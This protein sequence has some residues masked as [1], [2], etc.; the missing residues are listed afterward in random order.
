M[1]CT[2]ACTMAS[3]MPVPAMPSRSTPSRLKGS[4]RWLICS[5]SSPRPVSSTR[6]S[7]QPASGVA[8][9][10]TLPPGRLYLIALLSRLS[11]TW[12]SRTGSA[13]TQPSSGP[14]CRP[15]PWS[16]ASSSTSGRLVS[17][18]GASATG[19]KDSGNSPD[20][21]LDR[22]STSSISAS[23]CSPEAW[24]CATRR[25]QVAGSAPSAISSCEKPSTA[26]SGVRS[27]WLMRARK[28]D[29]AWLSRCASWRSSRTAAA[30][31][32]SV[33]SQL[34][35][36][37]RTV[38]P[39]SSRTGVDREA[40]QR[41]LPSGSTTRNSV[42]VG[43]SPRSADCRLRL[44]R[45]RSAG[46]SQASIWSAVTGPATGA[47]PRSRNICSSHQPIDA[48]ASDSQVPMPA[49]RAA[50]AARSLACRSWSS[51]LWRSVTSSITPCKWRWPATPLTVDRLA[52]R[53]TRPSGRRMRRSRSSKP[54]RRC[55]SV[56]ML[57]ATLARSASS[58]HRAM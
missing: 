36:M 9:T 33:M 11:S 56:A 27:S 48:T 43:E 5:A 15:I 54:S 30:L 3:P 14:R 28:R 8:L 45:S 37:R 55:S 46:C 1:C 50:S 16:R 42:L 47:R 53:R 10:V 52:S 41:R 21:R 25:G 20:C 17:A 23:R 4:N 24:M 19:C 32:T 2:D 38:R 57:S 49:P 22:S 18:S 26:L 13:S 51:V 34:M 44:Y 12:R 35:P 40:S 7:S 58:T 29:L 39:C 31:R 6:S